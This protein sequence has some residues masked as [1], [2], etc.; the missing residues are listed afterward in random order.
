MMQEQLLTRN[1]SKQGTKY[2]LSL[3]QN[4][5]PYLSKDIML[6]NKRSLKLLGGNPTA[7]STA[8]SILA[9][10][11]ASFFS[12]EQ[13]TE[14]PEIYDDQAKAYT[15]YDERFKTIL[16]GSENISNH[17]TFQMDLTRRLQENLREYKGLLKNYKDDLKAMNESINNS[18]LENLRTIQPMLRDFQLSLKERL[19][20]EKNENYQLMR[21]L[22][23]L[24]REKGRIHQQLAFCERRI[25]ELEK[26]VGVKAKIE[27]MSD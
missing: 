2:S 8:A 21:E 4:E 18:N 3:G 1:P 7:K 26:F 19:R 12:K 27:L 24:N 25:L 13:L 9:T 16:N 20:E 6:T 17:S 11:Q 14:P 23:D 15:N 5:G 22:E 10:T